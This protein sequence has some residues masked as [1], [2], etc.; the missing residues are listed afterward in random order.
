MSNNRCSI[1]FYEELNDF[2]PPE[3]RKVQFSH[4]FQRRA[5]IKDTIE[6]LGVPHTEIDLIL[7]NGDSV[8]FSY[9]VRDGDRIS[10]YP[11]FE[12]FDILPV[13]RVR[14]LP[15][16]VIRFVLDVHLGKLARYLRLLGF[17][18][19]YRNDYDD[20]EL[21]NLASLERRILLTRDRDLLKRAVVTHGY[22]VRATDPR[23]QVEE[24][25]DRLDLY[26]AMQ[27]FQRCVRCNGLLAATPKHRIE[28]RL[29]PE[30]RRQVEDF[31]ECGECGQLYWEGSHMPNIRRFID[32]L[33]TRG[34]GGAPVTGQIVG[35]G[36]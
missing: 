6:A 3:R 19:L 24:I 17:D 13:S 28:D 7:V 30:T 35:A 10:V 25:L 20:A 8:D 9:I 12:T 5:S 2:L 34:D 23:R 29:L 11:M 27:P 16:R 36:K 26:R 14:P 1:R 22:F 31:W 18:T 33:R 32:T 21:A 15:L 4:E